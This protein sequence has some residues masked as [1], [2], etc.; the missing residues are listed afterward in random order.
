MDLTVYTG[1]AYSVYTD[2]GSGKGGKTMTTKTKA[3]QYGS[4]MVTREYRTNSAGFRK[5]VVT[6]SCGMETIQRSMDE[7]ADFCGRCGYLNEK[8]GA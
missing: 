1:R 2:K 7:M 6:C 5:I 8:M 3:N 4:T